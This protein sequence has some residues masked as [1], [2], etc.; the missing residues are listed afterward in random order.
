MESRIKI[1]LGID[2]GTKRIGL[3]IGDS[4][5]RMASPFQ[6]VSDLEEIVSII[7]YE[8]IDEIVIG[9]PLKML[10]IVRDLYKSYVEFV[11]QLERNVQLPIR[12]ID[13]RLSSKH[14]DSLPGCKKTKAARDAV[15]A[16]LILQSYLDTLK[17]D[18]FM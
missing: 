16:M 17:R 3:A 5:T 10:D 2:W 15:A 18:D 8:E 7:S 1:Y 14:A 6:V 12:K 4:S 9:G 11:E 13:E